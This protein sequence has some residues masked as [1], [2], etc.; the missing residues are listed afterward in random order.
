MIK[1]RTTEPIRPVARRCEL[2][3]IVVR[4]DLRTLGPMSLRLNTAK[5]YLALIL[6]LGAIPAFIACGDS[7]SDSSTGGA[8]GEG[9]SGTTTKATTA[10]KTTGVGTTS[11]NTTTGVVVDCSNPIEITAGTWVEDQA[12]GDIAVYSTVPTPDG[13]AADPD[14]LGLELYGST[15]DPA[16]NGEDTGT[17][18]LT[19][20]GDDNYASCSR[21]LR[22]VED[23]E[24]PGR[25]FF[26][27]SGSMT[28][29][30]AST[31]LSGTI[32]ATLTDVMFVEVEIDPDT[33]ES[34]P[35]ANA[36]CLHLA[37]ADIAVVA[38]VVPAA[39]TC[40]DEFYADGA[41]DCG[42]AAFDDLDC[43]DL[44]VASCEFCADRGSCSATDCPGTIDPV[45]NAICTL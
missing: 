11:G 42:C 28:I 17:F 43:A 3:L 18:D 20:N 10:T 36:T 35:V 33:F 30:A 6:A 24:V 41:C 25:T 15:V 27:L 16:F 8:G 39:W 32:T 5:S 26:Q 34:T 37:T 29:D 2:I 45:N 21:C 44:T 31:Q 22:L 40:P 23:P 38:P 9:G 19:M 13:G 1:P 12:D 7:D 14:R 4:S